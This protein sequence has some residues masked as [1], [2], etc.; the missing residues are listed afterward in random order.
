MKLVIASDHGGFR[1]EE[2]IKAHLT[3]KGIE[4]TDYGNH[5]PE[6]CDYPLISE[7]TARAVADG[8]L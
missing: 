3:E 7:K 5:K 1:L 4:F 2:E 8:N 6:R